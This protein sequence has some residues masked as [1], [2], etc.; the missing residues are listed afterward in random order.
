MKLFFDLGQ[1]CDGLVFIELDSNF[2]RSPHQSHH[3]VL[4]ED[5]VLDPLDD[6]VERLVVVGILGVEERVERTAVQVELG[7]LLTGKDLEKK[8]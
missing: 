5:D 7:V 6:L 3:S 1:E 4:V 2:F 8:A